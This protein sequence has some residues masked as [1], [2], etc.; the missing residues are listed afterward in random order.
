MKATGIKITASESRHFNSIAAHIQPN[1]QSIDADMQVCMEAD[2]TGMD[3]CYIE[4]KLQDLRGHM[5]RMQEILDDMLP[6][7]ESEQGK[8]QS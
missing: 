2:W 8:E 1:A 3:R 7:W 5:Q 6:I 4:G